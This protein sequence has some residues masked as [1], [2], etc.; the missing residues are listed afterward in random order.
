MLEEDEKQYED[1]DEEG[2]IDRDAAIERRLKEEAD[3]REM[4]GQVGAKE[5]DWEMR[6]RR[7]VMLYAP[8]IS[9]FAI[10]LTFVFIGSG[11]A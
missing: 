9:G 3:K 10:I 7:P 1:D 11:Y 8:L 5:G 4:E 6:E 2:W